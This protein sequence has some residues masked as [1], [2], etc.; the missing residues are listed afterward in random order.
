MR[1]TI[2]MLLG[3]G[4]FGPAGA[5]PLLEGHVRLP[6]GAPV[7][8][9]QVLL[10]DLADLRAA[11]RAATTDRSGRFTLPPA[12]DRALPQGFELGANYPN[13][14]NP[15]TMIPYRLPASM[16]VRLEVFNLLGQRIATLVDG[17]QPAGFH[18]A[19]LGRHRCVRGSGGRRGLPLPPQR[20]RDAG[21]P[22]DAADRRAGG[23][24]VGRAEP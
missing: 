5:D 8:G 12:R 21:D 22:V 1:T 20:G 3:L 15:S 23:N 18:T 6:S 4:L 2:I 13:P 10:F 7:A 11:P 14:F 16:H 24:L 19:Q 9:A 17:E